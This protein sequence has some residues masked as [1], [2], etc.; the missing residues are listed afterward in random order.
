MNT[1]STA[2]VAV[3][4]TLVRGAG[5][6]DAYRAECFACRGGESWNAGQGDRG[7]QDESDETHG[8]P[9][10]GSVQARHAIAQSDGSSVPDY[11]FGRG[12]GHHETVDF[13]LR[14]SVSAEDQQSK[15]LR[16]AA[17]VSNYGHYVACMHPHRAVP[18]NQTR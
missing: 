3:R 2:L 15:R 14:K 11:G 16:Y 10:F 17:I 8:G 12:D 6:A 5:C 9:R 7:G 4:V 13:R 1:Q 18:S